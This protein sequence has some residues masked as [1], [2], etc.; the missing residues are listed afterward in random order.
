MTETIQRTSPI[1]ESF[2][3]TSHDIRK[4]GTSLHRVLSNVV[5]AMVL[6]SVDTIA[7]STNAS[8]NNT[9]T[10]ADMKVG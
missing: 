7:M 8:T 2:A 10:F 5:G 9:M 1:I 3:N 6:A 4:V